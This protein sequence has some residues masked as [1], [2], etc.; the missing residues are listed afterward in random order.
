M[1]KQKD[2]PTN[3]AKDPHRYDELAAALVATPQVQTALRS[4]SSYDDLVGG[5]GLIARMLKPL[6]QELL[7]A[8]M[9]EHLGY[10]K[11]D[12]S[13]NLTG[14]SRNGSYERALR[15]SD[16]NLRLDVPRDR[17]GNFSSTVIQPYK[18]LR[19]ALLATWP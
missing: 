12:A 2:T 13:G 15:G 6:M 7:D 14:N 10:P 8:E 17:N 5:E 3:N 16:G 19:R 18:Q 9:T 11:H 1:P 4:V